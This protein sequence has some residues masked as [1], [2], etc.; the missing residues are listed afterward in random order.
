[1]KTIII[2]LALAASACAQMT[3]CRADAAG[4]K[5]DVN[6]NGK[7]VCF[8]LTQDAVKAM[9]DYRASAMGASG[10]PLFAN[11]WA[12][13][14]KIVEDQMAQIM[15]AY[16]SAAVVKLRTAAANADAVAKQAAM[17][18]AKSATTEQ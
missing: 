14:K 7:P 6:A 3:V 1:M 10:Q 18:A 17:D 12:L 9:A 16:P 2:I 8:V 15:S 11:N 5:I 13:L 4:T